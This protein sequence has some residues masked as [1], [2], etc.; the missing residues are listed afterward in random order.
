M[1]REPR[2]GYSAGHLGTTQPTAT[3]G[4]WEALLRC[5]GIGSE[6]TGAVGGT[7]LSERMK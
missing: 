3:C 7:Y 2:Q 1:E 6:H 4:A 5:M